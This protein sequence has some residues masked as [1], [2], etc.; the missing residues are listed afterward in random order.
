MLLFY[1][2]K[3]DKDP[4]IFRDEG[5]SEEQRKFMKSQKVQKCSQ[6]LQESLR[7]ERDLVWAVKG[8]VIVPRVARVYSSF[9]HILYIINTGNFGSRPLIYGNRVLEF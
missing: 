8:S 2:P 4:S 7:F 9:H 5:Q 6:I 1:V 3:K